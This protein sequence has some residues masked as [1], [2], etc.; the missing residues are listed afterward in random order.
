MIQ[1]QINYDQNNGLKLLFFGAHCD[2]IEI[3]CGGT[4]LKLIDQY[5]IREIKWVGLCLVILRV[6]IYK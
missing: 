3:G 6:F 2:D 4:I 1:L 5:K